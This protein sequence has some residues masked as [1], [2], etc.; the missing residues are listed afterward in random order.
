[1]A[2]PHLL[3]NLWPLYI[4]VPGD[5]YVLLVSPGIDKQTAVVCIRASFYPQHNTQSNLP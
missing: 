2:Q 4:H 3:A 5:G 1:M